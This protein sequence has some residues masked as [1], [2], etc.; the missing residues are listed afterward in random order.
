MIPTLLCLCLGADVDWHRAV[1]GEPRAE[2]PGDYGAAYAQAVRE[3][4]VL[5]VHVGRRRKDLESALPECLHVWVR[6]LEGAKTLGVVV[7]RPAYGQL[8]WYK[9]LEGTPSP[10]AVRTALPAPE[11]VPILLAP[12]S[13][14][15]C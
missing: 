2:T 8:Y 14:P 5:L 6:E 1:V 13:A 12:V 9:E 3:N 15:S 11:R 4:K 7:S 10:S